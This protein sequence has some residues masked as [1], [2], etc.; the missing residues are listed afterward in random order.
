MNE[1]DQF[2]SNNMAAFIHIAIN[3][4]T[5][6]VKGPNNACFQPRISVG[7][8]TGHGL[9]ILAKVRITGPQWCTTV[10]ICLTLNNRTQKKRKKNKKK[11]K[12]RREEDCAKMHTGHLVKYEFLHKLMCFLCV[13]ISLPAEFP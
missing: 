6:M 7:N 5:V 4:S 9:P 11:K 3:F 1:V 10:L 13:V 2:L 8:L 12:R